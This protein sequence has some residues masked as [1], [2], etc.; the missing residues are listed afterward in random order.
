[1]LIAS[2]LQQH[3]SVFGLFSW[4]VC[5]FFVNKLTGILFLFI[6]FFLESN[7][8]TR[9]K[10]RW[11][12]SKADRISFNSWMSWL[13]RS[14]THDATRQ[15]LACCIQASPPG[16]TTNLFRQHSPPSH[17]RKLVLTILTRINCNFQ[18]PG[19]EENIKT[20]RR[21]LFLKFHLLRFLSLLAALRLCQIICLTL[22][23]QFPLPPQ[24]HTLIWKVRRESK[25][26]IE[27]LRLPSLRCARRLV[28]SLLRLSSVAYLPPSC[29]GAAPKI[30][31]RLTPQSPLINV[32]LCS[33]HTIMKASKSLGF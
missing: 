16:G 1:M 25:C 7:L 20:H 24:K 4:F 27:I 14:R 33:R 9:S 2:S 5:L 15:Q 23:P 28:S 29:Q 19:R 31:S 10:I 18:G 22:R 17:P 11:D 21:T 30:G 32:E 26:K 13:T 12:R 8:G 3:V 6:Y